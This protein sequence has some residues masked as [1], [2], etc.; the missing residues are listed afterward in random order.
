MRK[1]LSR[2]RFTMAEQVVLILM[3]CL[4][5]GYYWTKGHV[6][7]GIANNKIS[8]NGTPLAEGS[9]YSCFKSLRGDIFCFHQDHGTQYLIS[10]KDNEVSVIDDGVNIVYLEAIVVSG[11]RR[12]IDDPS[13]THNIPDNRLIVGKDFV[14]FTPSVTEWRFPKEEHWHISY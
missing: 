1:L 7:F 9:D 13:I 11:I 4:S 10:P 2:I 8:V 3:A 12:G 5:L 6:W 14:E